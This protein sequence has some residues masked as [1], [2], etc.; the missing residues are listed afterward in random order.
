[1][2]EFIEGTVEYIGANFVILHTGGFGFKVEVPTS[3]LEK[4][5][6]VG[7]KVRLYTYLQIREKDL[8]LYG[9]FE[10][11]ERDLFLLIL[12]VGGIGPKIGLAL[13]SIFSP[14]RLKTLIME[15]DI[16]ALTRVP[17]IGRKTAQRMILELKGTIEKGI[18]GEESLPQLE[19]VYL[20][21]KALGYSQKEIEKALRDIKDEISS[22]T[23]INKIIKL[24]LRVMD[25]DG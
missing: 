11:E 12:S 4:L 7:N 5:S 14:E 1:M 9:F 8:S 18:G 15:E 22:E 21:L 10:R 17:G 3:T 24:V 13:L 25:K 23:D 20:G 6:S 19:D 2:I 16:S